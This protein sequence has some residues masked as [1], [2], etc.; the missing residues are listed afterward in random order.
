MLDLRLSDSE[1]EEEGGDEVS[2]ESCQRL[3]EWW[4][5]TLRRS[6]PSP[7]SSAA[8]HPPKRVKGWSWTLQVRI[9][10]VVH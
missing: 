6:L 3:K 9:N 2:V 5:A 7:Q 10:R 8:E 4:T 1:S